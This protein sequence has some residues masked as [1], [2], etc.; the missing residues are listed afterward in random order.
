MKI[1]LTEAQPQ[2]TGFSP[3]TWAFK[4]NLAGFSR[5]ALL[6]QQL[7]GLQYESIELSFEHVTWFD[8]NLSA[9]LGAILYRASRAPNSIFITD[10]EPGITNILSRNGFLSHY[11]R[12]RLPDV[13]ETTV[14]YQR[15]EPGDDRFFGEYINQ[16]MQ[17]KDIPEMTAG[18]RKKFLEGIFEIFSNAVMHS[19]TRLGI[20][21]CGQFYP[22]VR[23]L[24][25]SVADLGVGMREKLC[26]HTKQDFPA[27]KAIEWAV[28]GSNT[29]KTGSVPGGLG[30]K[31]LREFTRLN[32]G[33]V[34]IVSD[35]GYWEQKGESIHASALEY[36]FPGTIVNLE[37][38][39]ADKKSYCLASELGPDDIL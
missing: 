28:T 7:D 22:R 32:G 5:L 18:L 21:V 16:H 27:E 37:L 23:R 24:D 38:N 26:R 9:P 31:L 4:S 34:Q 3:F 13:L 11:G 1:L 6:A 8:A 12:V 29:T 2:E 39:T 25:I 20:Y 15:L 19:E 14:S 33:R 36:P 10:V 30:L 17:G 35:R